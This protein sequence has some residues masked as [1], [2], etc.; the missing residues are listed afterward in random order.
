MP[1]NALNA[2]ASVIAGETSMTSTS[3]RAMTAHITSSSSVPGIA[4]T[5]VGNLALAVTLR[6]TTTTFLAQTTKVRRHER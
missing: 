6:W 3:E 1:T 5:A 4:S 2:I